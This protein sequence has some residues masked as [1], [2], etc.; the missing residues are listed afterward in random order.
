MK[1]PFANPGPINYN[2]H[3]NSRRKAHYILAKKIGL[4]TLQAWTNL[5]SIFTTIHITIIEVGYYDFF[6]GHT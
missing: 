4:Q 2:F 5:Y 6:L 3:Y 1:L